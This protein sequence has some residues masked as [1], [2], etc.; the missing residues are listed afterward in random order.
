MTTTRSITLTN[1]TTSVLAVYVEPYPNE[2]WLQPN[3]RVR[4][5]GDPGKYDIDVAPFDGGMTIVFGEDPD[6]TVMAPDG[7]TLLP[8]HQRP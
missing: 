8:G 3:E 1:D 6:P 7:A 5:T 4:I 2:Y